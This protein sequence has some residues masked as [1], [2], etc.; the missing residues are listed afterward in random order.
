MARRIHTKIK[1]ET[2]KLREERLEKTPQERHRY[3]IHNWPKTKQIAEEDHLEL[4]NGGSPY[5]Q[6]LWACLVNFCKTLFTSQTL[7]TL[8]KIA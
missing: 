7:K 6:K 4:I 8:F 5:P 2:A 3:E 1:G